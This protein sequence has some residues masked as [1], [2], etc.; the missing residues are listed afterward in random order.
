MVLDCSIRLNTI[1]L[2]TDFATDYQVNDDVISY[3]NILDIVIFDGLTKEGHC[4]FIDGDM[5]M[6]KTTPFFFVC[7]LL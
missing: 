6:I 4:A 7:T 1:S 3:P 5:S 2:T